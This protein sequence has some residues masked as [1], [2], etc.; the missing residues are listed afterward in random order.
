MSLEN[1]IKNLGTTTK[2]DLLGSEVTRYLRETFCKNQEG[3]LSKQILNKAVLLKSCFDLTGTKKGRRMIIDALN[4]QEIKSLGYSD[5]DDAT[6]DLESNAQKFCSTLGIDEKFIEKKAA[7]KRVGHIHVNA[8][9]GELIK[10]KGFLHPYQRRIKNQLLWDFKSSALQSHLCTMPTGAGKTTLAVELILDLIRSH[11]SQE[12]EKP[13][14]F[15][16]IVEGELLAEQSLQSFQALWNQK[17][18]GPLLINRYFS[19]F[20]SAVQ[21]ELPSAT[22]CTFSLVTNRLEANNIQELFKNADLLVIDEAHSSKAETYEDAIR[23]YQRLNPAYQILGLTATPYRPDDENIDS[24]KAIFQSHRS[25]T[26]EKGNFVKSPIEYLVN[27]D[28]LSH[29]DFHQMT[30]NET[31]YSNSQNIKELHEQVLSACKSLREENKNCII[32]AKN[33][34][35]AVALHLFLLSLDI[36]SGLIIGATPAVER[37]R[38]ISEFGSDEHNL[39]LL[40][41][42]TILSKGVDVPGLNSV[43]ILGEVL[44]PSQA[45]Q[46]LGRAMRGL[47]NGGNKNNTVY[48]TKENYRRISSYQ[49]LEQITLSS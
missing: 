25:I 48:L 33:M 12:G 40:I 1:Y 7:E 14:N 3:V 36:E 42:G 30:N 49:I 34:S 44:N 43:M 32:F 6:T 15:I 24:I 5:Y 41:N 20:E 37:E 9:Y 21:N 27:G 4:P 46:I 39:S 2:N 38:L 29:V 26:D 35:H 19:P 45:L 13:F 11:S 8:K 47:K 31:P 10:S 16:W 23:L 17:G 22:F 28:Y 18:D